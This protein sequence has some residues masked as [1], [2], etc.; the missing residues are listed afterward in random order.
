MAQMC[1][2][3][4]ARQTIHLGFQVDILS[5]ATVTLSLQNSAGAI[6][7]SDLHRAVLVSMAA[8]FARV[9]GYGGVD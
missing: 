8:K 3:T 6:S 7:A 1:C 2:D 5:D 4:T 9:V